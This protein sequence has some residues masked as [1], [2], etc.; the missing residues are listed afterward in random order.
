MK[1]LTVV[2][3]GLGLWAWSKSKAAVPGPG[4][5]ALVPGT[6]LPMNVAYSDTAVALIGAASA[7][8]CDIVATITGG[9]DAP[10][11]QAAV[12]AAYQEAA[13]QAAAIPDGVVSWSVAGG[14]EAVPAESIPFEPY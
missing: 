11:Y 3:I 10:A 6:P 2:L 13:Q 5:A 8:Q 1:G 7:A 12:D 9:Y 14:Y 4:K